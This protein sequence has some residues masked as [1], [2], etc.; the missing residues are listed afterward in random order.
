MSATPVCPTVV[1]MSLPRP[2][3]RRRMPVVSA[4]LLVAVA[5]AG[6]STPQPTPAVTK[7]TAPSPMF[8]SDAEALAAATKAYAAYLKV[9]DEI[10]HDGG[11]NPERIK[12]YATGKA[13]ALA[14]KSTQQYAASGAHSA[15]DTVLR[16]SYL[17]GSGSD[18]R[19]AVIYTCEDVSGVDVVDANGVSL[20]EPDRPTLSAFMVSLVRRTGNSKLIVEE[21]K[22][23]D[24]EGVC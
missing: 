10:S 13:L 7:K 19:R 14:I 16:N 1:A 20:V 3:P 8:A 12:P 24:S 15:G 5:L 6:C 21:R 17:Q 4:V 22:P 11:T 23:W 18:Q 9:S 2:I